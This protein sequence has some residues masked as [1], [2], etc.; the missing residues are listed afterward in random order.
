VQFGI[1]GAS[2]SCTTM[3][4]Y[5][6]AICSMD[7]QVTVHPLMCLR[8]TARPDRVLCNLLVAHGSIEYLILRLI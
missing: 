2:F 3:F 4:W 1:V 6:A 7:A 8:R 5:F